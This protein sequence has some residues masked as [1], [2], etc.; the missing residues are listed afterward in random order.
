MHLHFSAQIVTCLIDDADVK[1]VVR[2]Y[3]CLKRCL[4]VL[5]YLMLCGAIILNPA[6]MSAHTDTIS[7]QKTPK[8]SVHACENAQ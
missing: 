4:R 5:M 8:S 6:V 7:K 3:D 2:S 1:G